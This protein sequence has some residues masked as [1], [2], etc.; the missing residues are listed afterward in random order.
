MQYIHWNMYFLPR[1]SRL[2]VETK[3]I[4]EKDIAGISAWNASAI[5]FEIEKS[6]RLKYNEAPPTAFCSLLL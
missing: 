6:E 2:G 3:I 4:C 5:S 1:S